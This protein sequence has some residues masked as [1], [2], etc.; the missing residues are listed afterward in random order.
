M[1][2]DIE[3]LPSDLAKI[4]TSQYL[5]K[6]K[7]K[8][9]NMQTLISHYSFASILFSELLRLIPFVH[10]VF[11]QMKLF[12]FLYMELQKCVLPAVWYTP[13]IPFIRSLFCRLYHIASYFVCFYAQLEKAE[14]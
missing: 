4:Q 1:L 14:C 13:V 8:R 7:E 6:K 5:T 10:T 2:C 3:Y 9:E 12:A 11:F